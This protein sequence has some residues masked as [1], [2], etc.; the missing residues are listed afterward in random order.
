MKLLDVIYISLAVV[1]III[2]IHQIMTL[3]FASGYWAIMVALIFFFIY[4]LRR[5]KS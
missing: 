3:G 4:N 2:G 1:F 5:R